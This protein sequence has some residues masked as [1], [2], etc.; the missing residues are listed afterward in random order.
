MQEQLNQRPTTLFPEQRM[1]PSAVAAMD[2]SWARSTTNPSR[3]F[4]PVVQQEVKNVF[5]YCSIFD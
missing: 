2:L 5:I 1:P 3:H 4:G